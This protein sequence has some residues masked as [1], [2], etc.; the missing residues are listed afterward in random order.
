MRQFKFNGDAP[1]D[2]PALGV[3]VE[4]GQTVDVEDPDIAAGLDGQEQW[5][6]VPQS[7]AAKKTAAA[8]ADD[9]T[10]SQEG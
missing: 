1:V 10:D 4:P 5:E 7:R 9:N 6:H 8:Q 3:V 2:V